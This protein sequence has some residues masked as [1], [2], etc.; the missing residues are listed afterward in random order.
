MGDTKKTNLK[1]Y[2][3]VGETLLNQTFPS[4]TM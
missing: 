3:G 4:Q 1:K 2:A